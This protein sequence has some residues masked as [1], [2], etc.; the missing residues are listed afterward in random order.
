LIHKKKETGSKERYLD[1][2]Q[3]IEQEINPTNKARIAEENQL[4]Y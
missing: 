1:P 2:H 4:V 3:N